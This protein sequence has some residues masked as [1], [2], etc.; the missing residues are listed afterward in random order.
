MLFDIR[1]VNV[2]SMYQFYITDSSKHFIRGA[3]YFD[4]APNNDSLAP[5]IE[6]LKADIDHLIETFTWRKK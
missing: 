3:L 6:F 4:H 1:G 5:V 2:A